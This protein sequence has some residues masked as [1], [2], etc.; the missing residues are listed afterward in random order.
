M[1]RLLPVA[2]AAACATAAD[3]A[4]AEAPPTC[5]LDDVAAPV[6]SLQ[7]AAAAALSPRSRA[8]NLLNYPPQTRSPMRQGEGGQRS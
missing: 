2:L 5:L 1:L 8:H 6:P 4:P 3:I 7:A